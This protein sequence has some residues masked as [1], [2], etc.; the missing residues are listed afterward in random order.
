MKTTRIVQGDLL[1]D[2]SMAHHSYLVEQPIEV[3]PAPE[4]CRACG[5]HVGYLVTGGMCANC[6]NAAWREANS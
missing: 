2:G 5:E 4:T 3:D 1:P 6:R